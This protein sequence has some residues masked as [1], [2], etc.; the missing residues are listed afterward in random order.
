[1]KYFFK[2]IVYV[3]FILV[4]ISSCNNKDNYFPK[5]TFFDDDTLDEYVQT[6]YSKYFELLDKE[7]I[8]LVKYENVIRFTIVNDIYPVSI[9]I[10]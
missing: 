6:F 10:K 8:Y 1:M 7:K 3:I 5:N 4:I 9:K 2:H